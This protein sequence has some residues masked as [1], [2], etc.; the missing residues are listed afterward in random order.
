MALGSVA[1]IVGTA[2]FFKDELW[3]EPRP[4]QGRG[5]AEVG[6][7]GMSLAP[8]FEH[9]I[10]VSGREVP[11]SAGARGESAELAERL[12]KLEAEVQRLV[13]QL[14]ERQ[15]QGQDHDALP[16]AE[17]DED[18]ARGPADEAEDGLRH[19]QRFVRLEQ[20]L[21]SEVQS[22]E[23]SGPAAEQLAATIDNALSAL[24]PEAREGLTRGGAPDCRSTL[25]RVEFTHQDPE[26]VGQLMREVP[27][28]LGWQNHGRTQVVTNPDGTNTGIL[29]VS[30]D[31]Y[32]LPNVDD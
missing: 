4:A 11:E 16:V 29:Y 14:Q 1:L 19:A 13:R 23:W 3:G 15:S 7:G 26:V 12:R 2:W 31:G 8:P 18:N 32:G 28:A 22:P 9:P 5:Q 20:Y 21:A 30:R 10:E 25:C 6:G 17:A 24:P 27:H